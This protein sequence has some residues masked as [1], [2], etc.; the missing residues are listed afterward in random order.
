MDTHILETV[1]YSPGITIAELARALDSPKSSVY[2]FVRGLLAKG[3]LYE[4]DH[5]WYLGPRSTV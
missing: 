5:R 1:V 4:Q 3:W 2:G